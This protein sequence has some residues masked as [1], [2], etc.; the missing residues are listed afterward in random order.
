[1]TDYA[2]QGYD[3]AINTYQNAYGKVNNLFNPYTSPSGQDFNAA[4]GYVGSSEGGLQSAQ[5]RLQQSLGMSPQQ[6][7]SQEES[8]FQMSPAQQQQLKAA[9]TA[10]QNEAAASGF[11]GTP[12]QQLGLAQLT[13]GVVGRDQQ[14]YLNNLHEIARRQG[15]Q[16]SES[17]NRLS[18]MAQDIIGKEFGG[19][20]EGALGLERLAPGLAR[21]QVNQGLNRQQQR[22]SRDAGLAALGGTALKGAL[23]LGIM[24]MMA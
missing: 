12:S 13:S 2:N 14:Q 18:R 6:V 10:Q 19:A 9:Q 23:E 7:L 16:Y 21:T 22:D 4:R 24:A 17:Q 11:Y 1:M 3:N 8:G 15:D 5:S 20:Q